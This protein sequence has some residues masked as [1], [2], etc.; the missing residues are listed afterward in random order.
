MKSDIPSPFY[1]YRRCIIGFVI[2]LLFSHSVHAQN[3]RSKRFEIDA[4]RTGIHY[5]SRDALPRGREFKRID[6]TY[7]VGWM[8]EGTYLYEHAADYLGYKMAANQLSKA[9]DLM[10]RDFSKELK[11]R[12]EDVLV[13]IN[14]MKFHKDWDYTAYALM[15]CYS[16][17]ELPFET[18]GL[19]QRC[20]KIDL[21]DELYTDTYNY[22]SWTVHRNR[23]FTNQKF[24][25]L[26]STL[27]ENEQYANQLLDSSFTKVKR[28]AKIN[29]KI[30]SID[31]EAQKVPGIWHYKAMLYSYQLNIEKANYYFDK[32]KETGT[33]PVNNYATFCA[34]QAQF[35]DAVKFYDLAK[36]EDAGDKRMKESYYY[37]SIMNQYRNQLKQGIEELKTLI[38]ANGS[39][40]GFGWYNIA[41]AR[42]YNY[43]GQIELAAKHNLI[44]EQFKEIHIGTTLGKSH[45]EFS[46]GLLNLLIKSNQINALKFENPFWWLSITDLGKLAQLQFEKLGIQFLLINQFAENPERERVIYK[47]FSTESTVSF[48]EVTQLIEDFSHHYFIQK[49]ESEIKNDSRYQVKRYYKYTYAKILLKA[50]KFE[51]A[52]E[53]LMSIL[54]EIQIDEDYEKLLQARVYEN[55]AVCFEEQDEINTAKFYTLKLYETYPQLIPFSNLTMPMSLV[56][57]ARN[58]GERQKI[59][60][61]KSTRIE[62]HEGSSNEI[63]TVFLNFSQK[64]SMPILQLHVKFK[65]K[66]IVPI[67]ELP[68]PKTDAGLRKLTYLFF[69]I[70]APVVTSQ[71]LPTA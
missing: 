2:V 1:F 33:F 42:E 4:K 47:L 53:Q 8:Y 35:R 57:N 13:Y 10:E 61:I 51:E 70:G 60:A 26:K 30:F 40:P 23:F 64:G 16:N 65:Q 48:D 34:I 15:N 17:M 55:L 28:D 24:S 14:I 41:L 63:P 49:F 58:E 5:S 29:A 7:Y 52:Q 6:S 56:T 27:L 71:P 22:L 36:S 66:E 62:W 11:T 12:T 20:K 43:D 32:L 38:T 54:N 21:Q 9:L 44:A 18:W 68:I 67:I 19:L 59:K 31:F 3:L 45:Y 50:G 46:I 25:F 39:T 37:L 69:T